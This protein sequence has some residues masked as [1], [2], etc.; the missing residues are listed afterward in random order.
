MFWKRNKDSSEPLNDLSLIG[1]DMHSHILP[2]LDDG[3]Q[4]MYETVHMLT[5]LK[6]LGYHKIITTPHNQADFFENPTKKILAK[7]DEVRNHIAKI[8]FDIEIEAASEYYFDYKILENIRKKE[9]LTFG[10]N[11]L[12]FE[13]SPT[14]PPMN[15]ETIVFEMQMAGYRPVMAHPERYGYFHA[16]GKYR[17]LTEKGIMMQINIH[18][19]SQMAPPPIRKATENL[20]KEELV[21]FAGSDTHS[22][23][24]IEI[25]NRLLSNPYLIRLVNSGLLFNKEL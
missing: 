20:I 10:N 18:S 2:G 5:G 1:V 9:L 17:E 19:L 13:L 21:T 11:Y 25:M 3:A 4:E 23:Q 16:P 22:Y 24:N 14:L 7:L 8:G 6:E 12:L 15:F